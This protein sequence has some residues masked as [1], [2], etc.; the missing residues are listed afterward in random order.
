MQIYIIIQEYLDKKLEIDQSILEAFKDT[1]SWYNGIMITTR[2][3]W[4]RRKVIWQI[5]SKKL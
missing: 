3:K 2:S 4:S 1:K 5:I